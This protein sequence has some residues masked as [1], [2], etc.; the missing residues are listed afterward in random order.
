M[1]IFLLCDQCKIITPHPSAGLQLIPNGWR[2]LKV[3]G[4]AGLGLYC[5]QCLAQ[6]V[7]A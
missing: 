2:S 4:R 5:P 6:A 7:Y 1:T 3:V